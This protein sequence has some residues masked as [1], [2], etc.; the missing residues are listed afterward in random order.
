MLQLQKKQMKNL[1]NKRF[2]LV[3]EKETIDNHL[4]VVSEQYDSAYLSGAIELE[5]EKAKLVEGIKYFD[6]IKI[7][8]SK[9]NST[10]TRSDELFLEQ[11]S[12]NRELKS[13]KA[14]A[15]KNLKNLN[16]LSSLFLD[17]LINT[18]E[19][20]YSKDDLVKIRPDDFL[21]EIF[22]I[23]TGD[24]ATT[25]FRNIGSGGIKT[26]FKTSFAIAVHRLA[27]KI[28]ISILPKLLIIDT[29]MKNVSERENREQFEGFYQMLYELSST[30][31]KDTQVIIIDKEFRK[32]SRELGSD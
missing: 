30:E 5:R 15:E 1:R 13:M 16:E 32:P 9:I 20:G 12:L 4:N 10:E 27:K 26:R 19:K 7:I 22:H 28:D 3:K 11:Q 2:E 31:L 23:K 24:T 21:P 25:S 8:P 17:C 29:P 14:K 18:K 6:R